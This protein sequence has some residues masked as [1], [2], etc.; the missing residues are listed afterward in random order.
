LAIYRTALGSDQA[1][2]GLISIQI[3]EDFQMMERHGIDLR[4]VS[5]LRNELAVRAID[6]PFKWV[7]I[8]SVGAGSAAETLGIKVNDRLLSYRGQLVLETEDFSWARLIEKQSGEKASQPLEIMRG[9]ERFTVQAPPGMLGINME[10]KIVTG[11]N[12]GSH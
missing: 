9:A 12:A 10:D 8:M 4:A 2:G 3:L 7:R 11:E 5:D 6:H 1:Y